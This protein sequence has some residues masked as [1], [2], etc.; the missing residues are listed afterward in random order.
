M[1]IT[2]DHI[3]KNRTALFDWIVFSISFSLG[4]I[5][6]VLGKFVSSPEFSWWMLTTLVIYVAGVWLKHQPLS[7]RLDLNT[8]KR[9][10]PYLLLLIIGHWCIFLVVILFCGTAL[11]S[12]LGNS[13]DNVKV[14]SSGPSIFS[15]IFL[16]G[17]LTWL[18]FRPKISSLRTAHAS[19][20][21]LFRRELVADIFLATAVS[22]LS[23]VFWEKGV[24]AL[25]INKPVSNFIDV[26]FIFL[27]LSLTYVLCYL[28]LR[29]LFLLEDYSSRN[30]WK[31]MLLIFGFLL[32]K[33]V[34]E[35]IGIS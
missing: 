18:V 33:S 10:I 13:F 14:Y 8:A 28:P 22:F 12:M 17:L 25:L 19:V 29:Y 27:F 30:T 20:G 35:I 9:K 26:W 34:F 21:Y 31:R 15:A 11:F 4:F 7:D 1:M 3:K 23:F 16:S 5:F 6:P 2:A 24:M 32:L